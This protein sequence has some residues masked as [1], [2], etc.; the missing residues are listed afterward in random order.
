MSL[1]NKRKKINLEGSDPKSDS[2]GCQGMKNA[3]K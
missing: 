2:E 3:Q 1:F